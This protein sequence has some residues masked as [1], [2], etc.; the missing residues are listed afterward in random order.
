MD[1]NEVTNDLK[2]N[3]KKEADLRE[4]IYDY[5]IHWKW[6]VFS[7]VAFMAAGYLYVKLETPLYRIETDLLI[8][9]NKKG[10]GDQNDLLKELNLFSSDKIIDNEIQ[11]L[12]SN[13]IIEK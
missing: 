7:I 13:T 12:K 5:F 4:L 8:K 2:E 6:F 10:I 1:T 3:D 11:I 9:D